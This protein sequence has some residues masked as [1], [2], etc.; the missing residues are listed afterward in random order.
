MKRDDN[1]GYV[2]KVSSFGFKKNS[3]SLTCQ[4]GM[5]W[6][7]NLMIVLWLGNIWHWLRPRKWPVEK[8]SS[9]LRK[10]RVNLMT[11]TLWWNRTKEMRSRAGMVRCVSLQELNCRKL[12]KNLLHQAPMP[13]RPDSRSKNASEPKNPAYFLGTQ[14]LATGT[15]VFL[16]RLLF[17]VLQLD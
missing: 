11:I 9:S 4:L 2:Y 10:Y 13:R 17:W 8:R 5:V 1:R 6:F 7:P 12:F 15:Y 14:H 3:R 16:S